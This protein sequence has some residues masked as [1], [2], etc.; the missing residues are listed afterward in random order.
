MFKL[1]FIFFPQHYRQFIDPN[2]FVVNREHS[3]NIISKK[4]MEWFDFLLRSHILKMT[5]FLNGVVMIT[6]CIFYRVLYTH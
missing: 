1:Y 3:N 2:G 4:F 6:T 5:I